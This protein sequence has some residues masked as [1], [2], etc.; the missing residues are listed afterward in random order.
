MD[1]KLFLLEAKA[2]ADVKA[3]CYDFS[4]K[5]DGKGRPLTIKQ[6]LMV[7]VPIII[8]DYRPILLQ[9]ILPI[10]PKTGK[11][12]S[13]STVRNEM[14]TDIVPIYKEMMGLSPFTDPEDVYRKVR[15]YYF[16]GPLRVGDELHFRELDDNGDLSLLKSRPIQLIKSIKPAVAQ[17]QE[18]NRLL[19]PDQKSRFDSLKRDGDKLVKEGDRLFNEGGKYA[20][21]YSSAIE[22]YKK[23][24]MIDP[25]ERTL[26]DD[27]S[28]WLRV[29]RCYKRLGFY[30]YAI[31]IC[32]YALFNI[33][34]SDSRKGRG[35][36]LLGDT[37]D[38]SMEQTQDFS[39]E[40]FESIIYCW[41]K[42]SNCN[43]NKLLTRW[44][45][46]EAYVKY[47]ERNGGKCSQAIREL[48]DFITALKS[49]M[50]Q[51]S[52]KK[53]RDRL[54]EDVRHNLENKSQWQSQFDKIRAVLEK[55]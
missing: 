4:Q 53:Y 13:P 38:D 16:H 25:L 29:A 23:A 33:F 50:S 45:K 39:E 20:F 41:D 21:A 32:D 36:H 54:L 19:T 7:V 42:A 47:F 12:P 34:V 15:E 31:I 52:L 6:E 43:K 22:I 18:A 35:W 3:S 49:P 37:L 26:S 27:E 2:V 1:P 17:H 55:H 44:N 30:R 24:L 10:S 11:K 14:S 46:A 8:P 51:N 9:N 28:L 40:R 5:R 48:E